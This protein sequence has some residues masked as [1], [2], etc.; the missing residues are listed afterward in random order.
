[1]GPGDI[2]GW[3]LLQ[4]SAGVSDMQRTVCAVGR[5]H[6]AR[7]SLADAHG[8]SVDDIGKALGEAESEFVQ[9]LHGLSSWSDEVTPNVHTLLVALASCIDENWASALGE[10]ALRYAVAWNG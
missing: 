7:L 3:P 6:L 4:P 8:S 9:L 10:Y 5:R 2:R 1:M